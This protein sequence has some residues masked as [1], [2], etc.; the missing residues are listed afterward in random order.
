[1]EVRRLNSAPQNPTLYS[2]MYDPRLTLED[3]ISCLS[4]GILGWTEQPALGSN[5]YTIDET[6][7]TSDTL[8]KISPVSN[9]TQCGDLTTKIYALKGGYTTYRYHLSSS[10]TSYGNVCDVN[11][12][13]TESCVTQV[14]IRYGSFMVSSMTSIPGMEKTQIL[15]DVAAIVGAVAYVAWFLTIFQQPEAAG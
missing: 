3:L 10:G 13:Y 12:T 7:S 8:G 1:M 9:H 4:C 6:I 14:L 11:G 5:T 2:M 15:I